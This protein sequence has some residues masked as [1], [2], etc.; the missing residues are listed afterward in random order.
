MEERNEAVYSRVVF[1]QPNKNSDFY[2]FNKNNEAMLFSHTTQMTDLLAFPYKLF[3]GLILSQRSS[4]LTSFS[5]QGKEKSE[6]HNDLTPSY[7]DY[8]TLLRSI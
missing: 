3:T 1:D 6:F 5:K 8:V 2:Q 4:N 7:K